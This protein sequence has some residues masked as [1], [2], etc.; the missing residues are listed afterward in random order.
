MTDIFYELLNMSLKASY[1]ILAVIL[2]RLL[3]KKAPKK[4]S[5]AL[6]LCAAFRLV[7]PVSFKS[8]ISLFALRAAS[9][10]FAAP[11]AFSMI[12]FPIFSFFLLEKN[13]FN[14][15]VQTLSTLERASTL[16]NF[17]FV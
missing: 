3:L 10:T 14:P 16:P 13:S 11:L 17:V 6:W 15:C 4:Y 8:V 1:V 7:C 12:I 5:Y 9:L 2:V